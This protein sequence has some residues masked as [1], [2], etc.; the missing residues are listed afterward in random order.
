MTRKFLGIGLLRPPTNVD[1][2]KHTF[3]GAYIT[4]KKEFLRK[5]RN[6]QDDITKRD[7]PYIVDGKH[8]YRYR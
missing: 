6:I 3:A 8:Y 4:L 7:C 1:G 5:S 2:L